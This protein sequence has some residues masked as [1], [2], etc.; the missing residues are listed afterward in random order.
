[1]T[2]VA[3]YRV[4]GV[5]MLVG[6]FLV[7]ANAAP[8]GLSKKIHLVRPNLVVG[9]TGNQ[10]A[11][12]QVLTSLQ[13]RFH[14][15]SPAKRELEEFLESFPAGELGRRSV[16]LVGWI[17]DGEPHCF[18]WRSDGTREVYYADHFFVGTGADLFERIAGTGSGPEVGPPIWIERALY[19]A[20][21]LMADE[22]GTRENQ[23]AG[24]GHAYELL[25]F[26]GT[27]FSYVDDVAFLFVDV[28]FDSAGNYTRPQLHPILYKSHHIADY[29][30]V[31][32]YRMAS[33][34]MERHFLLPVYRV[35]RAETDAITRE[36]ASLE[37][38]FTLDTCYS[39]LFARLIRNADTATPQPLFPLI[40]FAKPGD[41][42]NPFTVK[43]EGRDPRRPLDGALKVQ[44]PSREVFEIVYRDQVPRSK[45]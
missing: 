9:W 19:S 2:L 4:A 13:D 5:P 11:A 8:A 32:I 31:E 16:T 28:P 38:P 10:L 43:W 18:L 3:A 1:V 15:R 20:C 17:V 42:P 39:C 30:I 7:T 22:I 33:R 23:A 26:N 24:F 37:Y 45:Q 36:I 25:S 41:D 44:L 12:D 14:G 34:E 40:M 35:D 29:T 21:Y 6:D 27:E